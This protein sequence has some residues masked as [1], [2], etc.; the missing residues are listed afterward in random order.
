[1][2]LVPQVFDIGFSQATCYRICHF[3]A[4]VSPLVHGKSCKAP[5]TYDL[6]LHLPNFSVSRDIE[7]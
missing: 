6:A 2:S 3:A 1:M 5:V 4:A 7:P